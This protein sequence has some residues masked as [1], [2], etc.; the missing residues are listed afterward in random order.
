MGILSNTV[1]ICQFQVLGELPNEELGEWAGR[2]LAGNAFSPIDQG[3]EELAFGWVH[4]DDPKDS[5]FGTPQVYW[6]DHYLVFTLRRDQRRVPG[7]LLKAHLEEAEGEFLA[8]H[9]GLQRVPKQKREELKEVVRGTLLARTLP[10]P[11]TYDAVWDT[12]SGLVTFTSLSPKVVELFEN[13]F[14]Q[15]FEGLRLVAVHP[16]GR[17]EGIVGE[18]LKAEL[19]QANQANTEAVLD[20]I[21]D[22]QWLGWDF[23][24]WLMHQTMNESSQYTV[25]R[26]GPAVDGESFVAYL[27]DRL[28]LVG[29]GE[30]GMQ[31]VTVAGPQDNF[32]E[33]RTA[34]RSGKQIHEAILYLEK[35]EHLWKLTLKG[36]T[37]H[38]AS[39]KA[40]PVKLEKD[41]RTDETSEKEAV[42]YERMYV[43]EEGLQ[44]FDSL[45][46]NFL[47]IR[48]GPGWT[49]LEG[50]IRQWLE[51]E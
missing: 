42:F 23:L 12:R 20:L 33:V 32:S 2:C 45:F 7:A 9:P 16:F 47:R 38:F 6:R 43:L 31:K 13:L 51:A 3:T 22:N 30:T 27:N 19:H 1:S 24:L 40:P 25:G 5:G 29:G 39:F 36:N 28:I 50:Q 34:L 18:A 17:A 46:G 21:Q 41:N 10:A 44:L 11:A 15:T 49:A 14:K 8:A 4:V 48:L 26:P 37:F 35:Q